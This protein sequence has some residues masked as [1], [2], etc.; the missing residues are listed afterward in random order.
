[1][2]RFIADTLKV[3]FGEDTVYRIGGDEFVV[4]ENSKT[5]SQ[6]ESEMS[7]ISETLSKND[8]HASIGICIGDGSNTLNEIIKTAEKRMYENKKKY[9]ENLG[10]DVRNKIE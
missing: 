10:K 5:M 8:Y 9:Y 4:F 3:S 6:L 7:E 1:M 2:L